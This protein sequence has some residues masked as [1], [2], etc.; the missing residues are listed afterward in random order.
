[1]KILTKRGYV[2]SEIVAAWETLQAAQTTSGSNYEIQKHFHFLYSVL[3]LIVP[4]HVQN[5]A[6]ILRL[7]I[8]LYNHSTAVCNHIK[9]IV[10][11]QPQNFFKNR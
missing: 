4:T 7:R 8:A 3:E 9:A 10:S 2:R 1:M 6:I 5:E 11:Y